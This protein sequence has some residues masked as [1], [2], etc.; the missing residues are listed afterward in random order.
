MLAMAKNEVKSNEQKKL[1]LM[2]QLKLLDYQTKKSMA[3]RDSEEQMTA[4]RR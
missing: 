1:E 3:A 2:A 4:Q